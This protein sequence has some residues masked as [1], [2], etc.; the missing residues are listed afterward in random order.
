[1]AGAVKEGFLGE[2]GWEGEG[3]A[4]LA[5]QSSK[6]QGPRLPGSVS[7]ARWPWRPGQAE[8]L[9]AP[10]EPRSASPFWALYFQLCGFLIYLA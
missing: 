7:P 10:R 9:H 6:E 2:R 3:R 8:G 5:L 4:V 1:M